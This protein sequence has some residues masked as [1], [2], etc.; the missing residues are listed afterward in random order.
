MKKVDFDA[1]DRIAFALGTRTR[2]ELCEKINTPKG[3]YDYWKRNGHIP[4]TA[5]TK[6]AH[7]LR[8]NPD[9]IITGEGAMIFNPETIMVKE[10]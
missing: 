2:I 8:L 4:I 5:I 1:I 9:W 6:I 10:A 7:D 3:T